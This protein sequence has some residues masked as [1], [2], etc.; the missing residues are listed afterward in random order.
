MGQKQ[1]EERRRFIFILL[2]PLEGWKSSRIFFFF[3]SREEKE[4]KEKA[5][6]K[7]VEGG[8]KRN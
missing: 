4:R 7:H 5:D 6:A 2:F 3:F 8:F 1:G